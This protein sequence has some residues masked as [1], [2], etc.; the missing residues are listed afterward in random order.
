MEGRLRAGR[1]FGGVPFDKLF[2]L[3]FDRDNDLW[4]RGH[5]GLDRGQKGSAPLGRNYVLINWDMAKNVYSWSIMTF[6]VGPFVDTGT[7]TDPTGDFGAPKWLWDTGVQARIRVFGT[8]EFVLG[9]GKDL[10]TGRNSFFSG[11]SP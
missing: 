1:T 10:R 11:V 3:G 7:I 6:A 4:M 5:P 8:F 9:W 2:V